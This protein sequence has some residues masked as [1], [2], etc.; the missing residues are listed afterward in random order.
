MMIARPSVRALTEWRTLPGTM[1]TRTRPRDPGYA[2]DRHLELALDHI[3]HFFL[4]M[5]VFVN[6][7]SAGTS[8]SK[9][10]CAGNPSAGLATIPQYSLLQQFMP[11]PPG[12][13]AHCG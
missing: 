7:G 4:R 3:P 6:G 9:P 5:E 13:L 12:T 2:A 1:P 8:S 10:N 11:G